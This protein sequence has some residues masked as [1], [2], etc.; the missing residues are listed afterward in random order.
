MIGFLDDEKEESYT[1]D[2]LKCLTL[3]EKRLLNNFAKVGIYPYLCIPPVYN[4]IDFNKSITNLFFIN[5]D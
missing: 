3:N 2:S 1:S 5:N 4:D